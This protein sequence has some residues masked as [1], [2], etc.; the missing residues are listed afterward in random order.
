MS[1]K[2]AVNGSRCKSTALPDAPISVP[3]PEA[4]EQ[5]AI[6]LDYAATT[7][8]DPAVVNAMIDFLESDRSFGNP[9]SVTHAYGRTASE[10]VECARREVASL[11]SGEPAEI[12]WTSGATEAI[13][14]ALK[15]VAF[16]RRSRGDHIVTSALEHK[17]VLDTTAWL[18]RKGFEISNVELDPAGAITA[19]NLAKALRPNTILVS[20]MHVNNETGTVTDI[21]A[22]EPLIHRHGALLHVDAVQSVARLP[23]EYIAAADL[24]SVSAHKMYGPKGIG[25]LRV[26]RCIRGELIPQIHGGGHE[27]GLRPG[28]LPTHQIVGMGCAAKLAKQRRVTDAKHSLSLELRLRAHFNRMEGVKINGDPNH[29]APGILSVSF[30]GVEAESLMFALDVVAISA[31]SACTSS[32]IEPSHVLAALDYDADRALSSVR[33]SFGRF[34]TVNEIDRTG[35]LIQEVVT[36]LRRVAR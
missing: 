21:A 28:T 15:G 9:A 13:N 36:D 5:E 4:V 14:L 16:A 19:E 22:L 29:H 30:A 35:R 12:I 10:T 31:G 2:R 34:T 24:I 11:L 27:F 6:Y 32:S 17:A 23:I 1:T 33:F 3:T 7:P 25:A 18:G 20:L 26:R 8:P